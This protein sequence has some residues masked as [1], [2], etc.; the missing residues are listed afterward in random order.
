MDLISV[1]TRSFEDRFKSLSNEDASIF[2]HAVRARA[3]ARDTPHPPAIEML[4]ESWSQNL[5][6][7]WKMYC[8]RGS[9]LPW[10][11]RILG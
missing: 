9:L 5:Q 8:E 3:V 2:L 7:A 4:H 1:S 6:E 11:Q 10:P